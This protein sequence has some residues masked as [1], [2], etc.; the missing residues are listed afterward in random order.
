MVKIVDI[1]L[2]DSDFDFLIHQC[3]DKGMMRSG[4]AKQIKQNYTSAF[5][6]Y[7]KYCDEGVCL[8]TVIS[9]PTDDGWILN[10]V[11]QDGYG[12]DGQQCTDYAAFVTGIE[13]CKD[14]IKHHRASD[15]VPAK[16]SIPYK[17]GCCRGGGDWDIILKILEKEFEDET[18][19]VTICR[20]NMG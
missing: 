6:L 8:G 7:K 5:Q 14:C 20:K 4:V 17:I 13:N 2:F 11:S 12:Y 9:A 3:N 1:D 10:M 16:I 15:G 18:Y 19:D